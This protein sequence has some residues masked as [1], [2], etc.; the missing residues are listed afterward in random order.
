MSVPKQSDRIN[1][2]VRTARAVEGEGPRRPSDCILNGH[3]SLGRRREP[4]RCLVGTNFPWP[5]S[6]QCTELPFG[7]LPTTESISNGQA[8][9]IPIHISVDF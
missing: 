7:E 4:S 3:V 1:Q 6:P 8:D 2:G 9:T 5:L